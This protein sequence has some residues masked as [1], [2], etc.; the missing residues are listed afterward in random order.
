MPRKTVFQEGAVLPLLTHSLRFE[1]RGFL[2]PFYSPSPE[3]CGLSRP[4]FGGSLL[5]GEVSQDSLRPLVQSVPIIPHLSEF[6]HKSRT[7]KTECGGRG[8]GQVSI[9]EQAEYAV[10][11][12]VPLGVFWAGERGWFRWVVMRKSAPDS[13]RGSAQNPKQRRGRCPRFAPPFKDLGHHAP[14]RVSLKSAESVVR[15][16]VQTGPALSRPCPKKRGRRRAVSHLATVVRTGPALS[17][18]GFGSGDFRG[19][20]PW[21]EFKGGVNGESK[22]F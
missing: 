4:P 19:P 15:G 16:R 10:G 3:A 5:A 9:G 2:A 12:L 21:N 13:V 14:S 22:K 7:A 20:A 17:R 6:S 18:R 8:G 11:I 1:K